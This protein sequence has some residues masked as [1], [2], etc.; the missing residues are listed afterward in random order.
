MFGGFDSRYFNDVNE[1]NPGVDSQLQSSVLPARVAAC[2]LLC[3]CP[4]P[5]FSCADTGEW[6]HRPR[7]AGAPP[8]VRSNH[9]AC[10]IG[11]VYYVF[12]GSGMDRKLND[13]HALVER[14]C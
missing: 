7:V 12:G 11:G 10:V 5:D 3:A 1:F 13:T 2:S 9:S 6:V 14:T 8:E 4:S